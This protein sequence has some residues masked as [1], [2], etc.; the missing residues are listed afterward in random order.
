MPGSSAR[1]RSRCTDATVANP[2]I[3]SASDLGLRC[4]TTRI[5]STPP[6]CPGC[7][8]V[9][10]AMERQTL[11]LLSFSNTDNRLREGPGLG[12][13]VQ[14]VFVDSPWSAGN[15]LTGAQP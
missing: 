10:R 12:R 4:P 15:R 9:L 8:A 3:C 5:V 11:A 13:R 14:L 7:P 2:A 1:S 6:R